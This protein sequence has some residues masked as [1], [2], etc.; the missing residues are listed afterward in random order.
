[1]ADTMVYLT[2]TPTDMQSCMCVAG[3]ALPLLILI[4]GASFMQITCQIR[5][6][7]DSSALEG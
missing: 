5:G 7:S 2:S 3:G 1:V 6:C 4:E